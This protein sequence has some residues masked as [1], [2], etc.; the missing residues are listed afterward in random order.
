[1]LESIGRYSYSF[2]ESIAPRVRNISE[3][4]YTSD[5]GIREFK[6]FIRNIKA[7][8]IDSKRR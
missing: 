6:Y 3:T 1:M 8:S 2:F 5:K 7:T 4:S